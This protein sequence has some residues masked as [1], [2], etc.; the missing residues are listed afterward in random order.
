[1]SQ[2]CVCRFRKTKYLCG[3]YIKY[4]KKINTRNV[5]C[6][7]GILSVNALLD[8]PSACVIYIT[9]FDKISVWSLYLLF[10]STNRC[11]IRFKGK[12]FH[13]FSSFKNWMFHLWIIAIECNK[14]HYVVQWIIIILIKPNQFPLGIWIFLIHNNYYRFQAVTRA[15]L[16]EAIHCVLFSSATNI[17]LLRSRFRNHRIFQKWAS[18]KIRINPK[19]LMFFGTFSSFCWCL[20][21]ICGHF[22][23]K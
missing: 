1:M 13:T 12:F 5:N 22:W 8:F 15:I 2:N 23:W 10:T 21:N 14:S 4:A 19:N 18:R 17:F 7:W 11:M 20:C 16:F 3:Y 9:T 6:R